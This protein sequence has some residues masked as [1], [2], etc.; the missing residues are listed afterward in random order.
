MASISREPEPIFAKLDSPSKTPSIRPRLAAAAPM[1]AS[2]LGM[3][4]VAIS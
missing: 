1:E 2:S 3:T 4:V